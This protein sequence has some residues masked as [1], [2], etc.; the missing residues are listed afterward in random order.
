MN[1]ICFNLLNLTIATTHT[2]QAVQ[3]AFCRI[4]IERCTF[5]LFRRR[6][7]DCLVDIQS[8]DFFPSIAD[9][10][11]IVA[12]ASSQFILLCADKGLVFNCS[13][14]NLDFDI[15]DCI[16]DTSSSTIIIFACMSANARG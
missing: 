11:G 13:K 14:K 8:L 4:Q 9:T 2:Y 6:R 1:I 7:H 15:S 10:S 16:Q 3:P 5:L 12:V